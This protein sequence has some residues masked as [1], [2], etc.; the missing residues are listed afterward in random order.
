MR[1]WVEIEHSGLGAAWLHR[2]MRKHCQ[3]HWVHLMG[4]VEGISNAAKVSLLPTHLGSDLGGKS[5]GMPLNG[6]SFNSGRS[7]DMLS[8]ITLRRFKKLQNVTIPLSRMNVLV[9]A[10]N[11][12]KSSV[13]Q[14]VAFAV[15]V[16]QTSRLNEGAATLAPEQLIYAPLRDVSALAYGGFLRQAEATAIEVDFHTRPDGD[17]REEDLISTVQIRRGRNSNLAVAITDR[18][19]DN[20]LGGLDPPFCMYVPG[21]AGLTAVESYRTPAALRR[22]AARGDANSVLRNVLLSLKDDREAWES[23]SGHLAEIF[24]DHRVDLRFDPERDEV[25]DARVVSPSGELPIDAAGT[26][27]LQIVQILA[28]T[29]RFRPKLLLLDEPDAH[30]HPDKQRELVRLLTRLSSEDNFQIL[31]AT[32][33]RH[34]IDAMDSEAKLHWMTGGARRP[35][36]ET[37]VIAALTEI[38]ALDRGDHL[39]AGGIDVVLLTEDSDPKVILPI[40]VASGLPEHR[41]EVWSYATCTQLQKAKVL[42]EFI[43]QH[44]PSTEVVVH[45]DRDY[46]S[47]EEVAEEIQAFE[48]VGLTLFLTDGTDAESHYLTEEHLSA[49]YP[50]LARE[51]ILAAI[52][53]GVVG[54][55]GDSAS[56]LSKK[57]YLA[58]KRRRQ[59]NGEP[60][61]MLIAEQTEALINQDPGRW[62]YGKKA[63]GLAKAHIQRFVYQPNLLRASAALASPRIAELAARIAARANRP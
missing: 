17:P 11:S 16:A 62:T 30:I 53:A 28:Y 8:A 42:A 10:N 22:A 24:P 29:A 35:D 1:S 3:R 27:L 6:I 21:L 26:G 20:Q 25:V 41:I 18:G 31:I 23:F 43:R 5:G 59:G 7:R 56:R 19:L 49:L 40:M 47:D 36:E 9:G 48:R 39:R 45:L 57:L 15:S 52:N 34:V 14:G 32:H 50:E 54:A 12:G 61:P 2:R 63:L 46:K 4:L 37:D 51:A 60:N 33:S 44:A 13:L 38:G 55:R 58:E